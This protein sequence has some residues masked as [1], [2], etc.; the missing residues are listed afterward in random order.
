MIKDNICVL[1]RSSVH[2][3]TLLYWPAASRA[4]RISTA[5]SVPS[6]GQ[7]QAGSPCVGNCDAD[8][9]RW[10][11]RESDESYRAFEVQLGQWQC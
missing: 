3:G 5:E 6:P 8:T 10:L 9:Q 11:R 2:I 7:K 1:C 4:K